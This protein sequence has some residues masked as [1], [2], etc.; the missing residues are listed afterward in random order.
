MQQYSMAVEELLT[1]PMMVAQA[2]PVTPQPK[3]MMNTASSTT[4]TPLQ[5]MVAHKGDLVSP[6]PLKTPCV[7]CLP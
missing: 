1:W 3:Y 7:T 5:M 2:A 6:S 4:L